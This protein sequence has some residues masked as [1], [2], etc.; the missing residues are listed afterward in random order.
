MPAVK[1]PAHIPTDSTY[2]DLGVYTRATSTTDKDAQ[3]WFD[4]GLR[5]LF[6]FNHEAAAECFETAT[7]FDPQFGLAHWGVAFALGPNYNKPWA[8][9]GAE[10]LHQTVA[11]T[12]HH[13]LKAQ[14]CAGHASPA[15][16]AI[17]DAIHYR[18]QADKPPADCTIWNA[19]FADAMQKAY[20]QQGDD[21]EVAFLY[22]DSLMNLTPW[23]LWDIKAGEANKRARTLEAKAVL[24]K[25][26]AQPG[27]NDHPGLLHLYV[28]LMEMSPTPE[29]AMPL[30][31][32]LRGMLAPDAGHLQHMATHLDILCGDYA[33]ASEWN[34]KALEADNKYCKY[35]GT[36]NFYSMY[37]THNFHFLIYAS[38]FAGQYEKA[39]ETV[40]RMEAT[41]PDEILRIKV[42]PMADW[43]E[44]NRTFRLHVL[45]RFGKW[46]EIKN[47]P[48][49]EDQEIYCSTTAIIHYAKGIAHAA[50]GDVDAA[51]K[52]RDL[53]REACKR[54]PES[55]LLF[56]NKC[57]V[58]NTIAWAMLDGEIEYRKGNYDVAYEHLRK[59]ID[60]DDNL[61]YAEPWGWMQPTRHAYGALLL[62][63]GHVE[64]ALKT[65]GEDLGIIKTLPRPLQH[66][67]NVWALHGYH[68]CLVRLGRKEEAAT[69]NSQLQPALKVADVPIKAS[70]FCRT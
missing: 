18:Y 47:M 58:V 42:P 33:A 32:R 66:P 12:R 63:Q 46:A 5:W 69:I 20:E 54:V 15:E 44:V 1:L 35:A 36:N 55:R 4:R 49:P 25:A 31:N 2:Y 23:E 39:I 34:T 38:M 30:G 21:L 6:G 43:M 26:V 22:A 59:A 57:T 53:F 67:N 40:D 8:F 45:V 28:H 16:K 11:K 52:E 17:I 24:E 70:C 56:N 7:L 51:D 68:E 48:L 62:E 37:R 29:T 60:I 13:V 65:Y 27:G 14:E 10:E 41:I 61:P 9:F 3:T 64:E 19:D 50:T